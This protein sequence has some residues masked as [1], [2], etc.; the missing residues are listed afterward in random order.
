MRHEREWRVWEN[1]KL[2]KSKLLI[3]RSSAMKQILS[4]TPKW[5][6]IGSCAT[7]GSSERKN[8]IAGTD[9]GF[10]VRVH[11]QIARAK[12]EALAENAKLA[13]NKLWG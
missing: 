9:C 4:S 8:V 12:L 13:S 2:P 10:G 11:P 3:P 7:P 6:P 1:V 5:S